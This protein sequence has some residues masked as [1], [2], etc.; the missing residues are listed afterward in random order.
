MNYKQDAPY[1]L[2]QTIAV[3][4]EVGI[5]VMLVGGVRGREEAERVVAETPIQ[6]VGFARPFTKD[7]SFPN[8]WKA[9]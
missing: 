2:E 1:F 7:P 4:N 9:E 3:S 8:E 6:L 5:P